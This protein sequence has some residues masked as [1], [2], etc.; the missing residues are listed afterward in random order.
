MEAEAEMGI[1]MPDGPQ[2][3]IVPDVDS[4]FVPDASCESLNRL[5]PRFCETAGKFPERGEETSVLALDQQD[6]VK[7]IPDDGRDGVPDGNFFL[8]PPG[9]ESFGC[10][11][12]PGKAVF[13][14]GTIRA[15]GF[16][17]QADHR[18]EFHQGLI[19]IPRPPR[20]QD[21]RQETGQ[22]TQTFLIGHDSRQG[23][24]AAQDAP[25]ISVYR[26]DVLPE[27]DT[28]NGPRRVGPDTGKPGKLLGAVRDYPC[29]RVHND[30]SGLEK[31]PGP[32]VVAQVFPSMIFS[33]E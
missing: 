25:D 6:A 26:G 13:A 31:L 16:P 20:R 11:M 9:R 10:V 2:E 33:W 29:V 22:V 32:G 1:G 18:P 15:Q 3:H 28:R 27:G 8:F 4:G 23:E 30:L 7:G 5:F 12:D 24:I 19:E 21:R 14:E 17:G